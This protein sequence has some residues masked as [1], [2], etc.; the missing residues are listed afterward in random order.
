MASINTFMTTDSAEAVLPPTPPPL[1]SQ[2]MPRAKP[3][4]SIPVS[5]SDFDMYPEIPE[6]DEISSIYGAL[7]FKLSLMV[8]L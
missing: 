1:D 3:R 2:N 8:S 6:D 7:P 5:L 4:A